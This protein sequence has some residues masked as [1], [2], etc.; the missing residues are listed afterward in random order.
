VYRNTPRNQVIPENGGGETQA[1]KLVLLIRPAS[2][3]DQDRRLRQAGPHL[4]GFRQIGD[5]KP[6]DTLTPKSPHHS[7]DPVTVSLGF[8]YGDDVSGSHQAPDSRSIVAQTR[9][10]DLH[11]SAL[12]NSSLSL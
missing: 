7:V 4:T 10:R 5:R 2:T 12:Q 3:E 1:A 8:D 11:P 6:P 9:Q